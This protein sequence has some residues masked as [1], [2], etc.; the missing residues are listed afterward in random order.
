MVRVR[1]F[2][3]FDLVTAGLA[4]GWLGVVASILSFLAFLDKLFIDHLNAQQI[5][6]NMV[7]DTITFFSS[8]CLV[9]GI[10]KVKQIFY[11]NKYT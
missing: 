1:A 2:F 7:G 4:I 10:N 8:T 6:E 9:T 3:C 11:S 5:L